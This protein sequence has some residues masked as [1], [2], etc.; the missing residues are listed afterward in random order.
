MHRQI[1]DEARRIAA[2]LPEC[3]PNPK[4]AEEAGLAAP[5]SSLAR[6]HMVIE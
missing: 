1:N 2:K 4:T 5:E 6:A 3:C